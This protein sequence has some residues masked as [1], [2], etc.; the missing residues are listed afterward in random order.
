MNF[1]EKKEKKEKRKQSKKVL[2]FR[3]QPSSELLAELPLSAQGAKTMLDCD[4][5]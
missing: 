3:P 4:L 2:I 1:F 5:P